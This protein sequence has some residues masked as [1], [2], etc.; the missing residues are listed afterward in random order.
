M[1]QGNPISKAGREECPCFL[2]LVGLRSS[3]RGVFLSE[4]GIAH[5]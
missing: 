4:G 5:S 2:C 1:E 3:S